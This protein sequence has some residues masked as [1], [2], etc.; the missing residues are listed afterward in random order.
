LEQLARNDHASAQSLDRAR[1]RVQQAE[2]ELRRPEAQK[3][4]LDREIASAS[5]RVD[6]ARTELERTTL[7]APR[8]GTVLVRAI[9][10]GEVTQPGQPLALL[11]DLSRLELKVY[12]AA[13]QM[14][15]VRPGDEAR[16]R[17]DASRTVVRGTRGARG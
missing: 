4:S 12:L 16:V 7:Y 10:P 14:G 11:V 9:E 13:D 2:G 17:V 3:T 6:L 15:K 5:S 1:D 8:N